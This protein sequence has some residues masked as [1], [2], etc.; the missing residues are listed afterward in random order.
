[1]LLTVIGVSNESDISPLQISR[2]AFLVFRRGVIFLNW[3]LIVKVEV[4]IA[5]ASAWREGLYI[6]RLFD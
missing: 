1:M 2:S 6:F 4:L 3:L 5:G